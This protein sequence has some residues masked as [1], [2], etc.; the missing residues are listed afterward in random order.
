MLRDVISPEQR[1][2]L[3][4]RFILDNIVLTQ[5]TLHWAKASIQPMFFLKFDFSKAY[6]KVS[7]RFLFHAMYMF[8]INEEF[9][10]W[11]R[12]LFGSASA[13]TNLNGS[14]R[15]NFKIKR[16]VRQWCPL[17][18]YLFIIIGEVLTHT[19]KKVVIEGRIRR[20]TLPGGKKTTKHITICGWL[21][22]YD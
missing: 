21:L 11:V 1:V 16:G 18:L 6:N 4:L 2:F 14:P 13:T 12:L 7:S 19:I 15:T 8:G 9:I 5:E 22:V 20:T 3:P 17:A 10:G